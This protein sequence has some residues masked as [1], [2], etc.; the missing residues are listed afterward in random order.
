MPFGPSGECINKS[1]IM[2]YLATEEAKP[3]AKDGKFFLENG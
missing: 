1:F 3:G 2:N